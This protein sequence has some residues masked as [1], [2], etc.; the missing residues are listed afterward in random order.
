VLES[1]MAKIKSRKSAFNKDIVII[2]D[3]VGL[4]SKQLKSIDDDYN[5]ISL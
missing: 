2:T 1:A 4:E 5:T 3:A